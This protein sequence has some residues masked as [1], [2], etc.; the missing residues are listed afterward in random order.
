MNHWS[1]IFGMFAVTYIPRMLP[2][3]LKKLKFPYWLNRWLK[4]V[5]YAVLGALIFPGVMDANSSHPMFGI[6]A[7]L[8]AFVVASIQNNLILVVI[9]SLSAMLLL[10]WIV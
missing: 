4:Y 8:V 10:Q 7:G 3:L 1:L 9:S 2:M 5:P 6:V